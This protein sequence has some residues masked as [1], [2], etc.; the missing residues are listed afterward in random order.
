[1]PVGTCR[2][3]TMLVVHAEGPKKT[4]GWQ[5]TP[6]MMF[7][8]GKNMIMGPIPGI[9]ESCWTPHLRENSAARYRRAYRF[10]SLTALKSIAGWTFLLASDAGWCGS[11][12]DGEDHTD[13]INQHEDFRS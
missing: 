8:S 4:G 10:K 6:L 1:M 11:R 9:A 5:L 13:D 2:Q 12:K 3:Q 7:G